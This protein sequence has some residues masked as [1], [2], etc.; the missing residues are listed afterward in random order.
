[1]ILTGLGIALGA[2]LVGGSDAALRT[3]PSPPPPPR[4]AVYAIEYLCTDCRGN[5]RREIPPR[6]HC[7]WC[8]RIEDLDTLERFGSFSPEVV[9]AYHRLDH[10]T[11]RRLRAALGRRPNLTWR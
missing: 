1:M 10:A 8:Q 2:A 5:V 3:R 7:E 11:L 6:S 4:P 9:G